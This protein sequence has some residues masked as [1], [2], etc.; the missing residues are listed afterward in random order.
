MVTKKPKGLGRGLS[1]LLGPAVA[2][3][4]AA[5]L[6][7]GASPGVPARSPSSRIS[8]VSPSI[9]SSAAA[10]KVASRSGGPKLS[11]W[12]S[13]RTAIIASSA[14]P[15]S[16]SWS[17]KPS[18]MSRATSFSSGRIA[19]SSAAIQTTP[20]PV[21]AS[22]FASGPTA[23]GNSIATATKNT[24]GS[25]APL[26]VKGKNCARSRRSSARIMPLPPR[27]RGR[28][29][30]WRSASSPARRAAGARR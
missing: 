2:D 25:A 29:P 14:I 21:R 15:R 20:P 9:L 24:T 4:P 7:A 28:S 10:G 12:A 30:R 17:K 23:K 3:T 19:A 16:L 26:P 11:Q 27:P 13:R 8:K 18:W 6:P 22:R 1:A 5:E